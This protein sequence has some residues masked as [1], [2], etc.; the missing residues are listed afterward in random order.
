MSRLCS[1]TRRSPDRPEQWYV[2]WGIDV[3]ENS[4]HALLDKEAANKAARKI[5]LCQR[6][7]EKPG[8]GLGKTTGW[9]H[10]LSL[11]RAGVVMLNAVHYQRIDDAGLHIIKNGR[12]AVLPVDSVVICAGQLSNN[13]LATQ[14]QDSGKTVHFIGGADKAIELDAE[15]AI[16]QAAMLAQNL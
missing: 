12:P 3:S 16:R 9:I 11:R 5:Y 14:L 4:A 13:Q 7:S 1:R 10:R 8:K 6:S 2:Q 15:R